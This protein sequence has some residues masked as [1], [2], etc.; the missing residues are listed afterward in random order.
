VLFR[1]LRPAEEFI[2]QCARKKTGQHGMVGLPDYDQLIALLL[3]DHDAALFRSGAGRPRLP[4]RRGG[5]AAGMA[6]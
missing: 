1:S 2:A 6:G 5:S 4:G 3:K